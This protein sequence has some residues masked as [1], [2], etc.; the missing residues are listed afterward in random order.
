M[1]I[2]FETARF[3]LSEPKEYFIN[4]CCFGDDAAAWF[5]GELTARGITVSEPGQEDWGWYLE[6]AHAGNSYFI[7]I[8]GNAETEAAGNQGEWRLMLEK[9]RTVWDKLNGKNK[10]HADEQIILILHDII[11]KQA[12]MNPL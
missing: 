9:K 8:G 5:A 6:A 7:G 12:D 2:I 3:N 10:L 4:P 1:E 11:S